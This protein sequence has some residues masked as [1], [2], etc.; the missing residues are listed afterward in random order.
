LPS[1]PRDQQ[2]PYPDDQRTVT[3]PT[4]PDNQPDT[5]ANAIRGPPTTTAT[6]EFWDR[7]AVLKF[8]GGSRPLHVST[9]YRGMKSGRYP[10]PVHVSGNSVRWLRSECEA[11]ARRMIAA[12]DESKLAE[13]RGRPRGKIIT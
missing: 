9:L 10:K 1:I 12:R 4:V 3:A 7:P 2:S 6:I 5:S 13:P 11:A 8:F